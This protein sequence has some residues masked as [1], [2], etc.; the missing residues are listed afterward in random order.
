M[1]LSSLAIVGAPQ[2][3]I[4]ATWRDYEGLDFY[5]GFIPE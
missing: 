5:S 3:Y 2:P 1:E 4:Y